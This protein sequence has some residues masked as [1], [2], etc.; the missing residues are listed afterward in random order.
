MTLGDQV[1]A[2]ITGA[3][4]TPRQ[5]VGFWFPDAPNIDVEAH[6]DLWIWRMRGGA[7]A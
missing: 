3:G 6:A 7:H 2:G 1:G 4:I 5:I